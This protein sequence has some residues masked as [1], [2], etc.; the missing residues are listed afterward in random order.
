MSE[1]KNR[2]I[3]E[4]ASEAWRLDHILP[5]TAEIRPAES[6]PAAPVATFAD[7][8]T[9]DLVALTEGCENARYEVF[10]SGWAHGFDA[11]QAEV[12]QLSNRVTRLITE[13]DQFYFVAF[14]K[15]KTLADYRAGQTA[16]LWNQAVAS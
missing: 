11:R 9:V 8:V 16:E 2:P 4:T 13:R 14:N 15:G 3:N 5:Q 1:R 12:D 6:L 7:G 10:L